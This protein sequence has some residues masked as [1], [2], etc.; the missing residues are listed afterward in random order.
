MPMPLQPS[1]SDI[2]SGGILPLDREKACLVGRVWMDSNAPGPHVAA[3]RD[4]KL[5]DLSALAPTMADL[6]DGPDIK[7]RVED[8]AGPVLGNV[9]EFLDRGALLAPCDLQAVKASGVTFIASAIERVIEERCQG[10]RERA[11]SFRQSLRDKL[12]PL[13]LDL[14]PGSTRANEVKGRLI[15]AGL[16]SQYLEVAIGPDPEIFTKAQPMS[17][18]GCGADIGVHPDS[19]WNNPEP[20]IVL[21][22][23]PAGKIIGA[24]LGND[25]NLRD[26][27][28]R[29]ALLLGK[30]KD[31]NASCAIGPF[32]RLFDEDFR[33]ADICRAEV[34]L[35]ITGAD[36][37]EATGIS[38]MSAMSRTPQ[39]LAEATIG[40]FHQ[41]P[42]GL[43]LFL[44]TTYTPTCDRDVSGGGFT[45]QK[46]DRVRIETPRL[47]ALENRVTTSDLAPPWRYGVRAL[48]RSLAAR[49]LL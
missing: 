49:Q 35:T 38:T 32:I 17:A 27:E 15:E 41:Y 26:V 31:N 23:S 25:V 45:H 19:Q 2:A 14:A 33:L 12:E 8:H 16:W 3:I 28:S 40:D 5:I 36:G 18:V 11:D 37:F 20:E 7:E 13:L 6:L 34:T 46:G 9:Q 43:M 29:S 39:A 24:S 10:A 30:A 42:D 22:I 4:D 1:A 44:G 47:G 48:M 21:A